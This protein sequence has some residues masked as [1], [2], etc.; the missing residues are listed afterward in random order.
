MV[1]SS[2]SSLDSQSRT[3]ASLLLRGDTRLSP[4]TV[5]KE[6]DRRYSTLGF[7]SDRIRPRRN[8]RLTTRVIGPLDLMEM[9]IY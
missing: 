5:L 4:P 6:R 7:G 1:G 9:L 8:V 2:I 3:F